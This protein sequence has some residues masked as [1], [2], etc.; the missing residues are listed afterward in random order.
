M[1]YR[2]VTLALI[3]AAWVVFL[4]AIAWPTLAL[5][6]QSIAVGEAPRGGFTFSEAQLGLLW[7][8]IRLAGIATVVGVVVSLPGAYVVGRTGR[9]AQRPLIAALLTASLL[10]PPAVYAFGWERILPATF[11]PHVRCVGVWALWAWPIPALLI[12]TGWSR[13]GRRAYEA[14][15]LVATPSAAFVRVVLPVLRRHLALS[16]LIL[17][18]LYFGDYCVPHACGLL[19]YSTELLIQAK[20]SRQVI[21]TVWPSLLAVVVTGAALLATFLIGHRQVGADDGHQTRHA[22]GASSRSLPVIALGCLGVSWLLPIGALVWKLASPRAIAAAFQTYSQDLAWSLGISISSGLLV[23]VMGIGV[24]A[25][26]RLRRVTLVWAVAFA[27]LPGAL[28][29]EALIAAYNYRAVWWLY[30]YWPIVMVSYV[31]RFG[32]VGRY[33]HLPLSWSTLLCGVGVVAALSIAEV[34]TS[35]LV[36]VPSFAPVAHVV[37]EKFHRFEDDMLISLS[38]WL[39]TAGILT[40]V[41]VWLALRR[42]RHD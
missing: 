18:M 32:W 36:R 28:I 39:V 12:G 30:D 21:D 27:A 41:L 33:I 4:L 6:G 7:R 26:R 14:A 2:P 11:D 20:S 34:P 29:G 5:L 13:E 40:E 3:V 42:W 35:A 22:P 31:A 38:L 10:C 8:S 19:V 15:I 25:G 1:R 9:L 37:F 16:M 17:F 24:T 23:T